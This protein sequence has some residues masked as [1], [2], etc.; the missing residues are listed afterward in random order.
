M[1]NR[2]HIFPDSTS[3]SHK[4]MKYLPVSDIPAGRYY[5]Y[6]ARQEH[7]EDLR[8]AEIADAAY[9]RYLSDPSAAVSWEE[10]KAILRADGLLDEQ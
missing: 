1:S 3:T 7:L 9:E 4:I 10:A 2:L 5:N 8:D 6:E